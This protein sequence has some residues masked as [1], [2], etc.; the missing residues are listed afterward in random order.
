MLKQLK[1]V[2]YRAFKNFTVT[3]GDGAYLVGPNNAGKSTILT[4]LRTADALV[5]YAH[6]RSPDRAANFEGRSVPVY[7]LSLSEFPAL[8]DSLRYEFGEEETRM[9]LLWKSGARLVAVWPRNDESTTDTSDEDA[10]NPYFYLERLPG[11][12]V[13]TV[14]QTREAFPQL[15]VIPIL[16]PLEHKEASLDDAYVTRNVAGRLSPSLL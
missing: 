3:F 12:A 1:L 14:V 5:R 2:N 6:R 10:E 11:M 4:A 15:G 8:E 9:E 13:R 16:G 7:P